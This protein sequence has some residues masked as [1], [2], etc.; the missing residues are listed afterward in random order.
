MFLLVVRVQESLQAVKWLQLNL[1]YE[2][3]G[4]RGPVGGPDNHAAEEDGE[5]G[6]ADR[7]ATRLGKVT[8]L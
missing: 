6:Q 2:L 1:V 7:V 4:E 8:C 3:R 5:N